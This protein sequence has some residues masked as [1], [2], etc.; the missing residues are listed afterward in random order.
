M[1]AIAP[2]RVMPVTSCTPRSRAHGPLTV[3]AVG[4]RTLGRPGRI[5]ELGGV[6]IV[7][8]LPDP[9]P[10]DVGH[11]RVLRLEPRQIV[12][13]DEVLSGVQCRAGGEREID[14]LAKVSPCEGNWRGALV[15]Q[16]DP[17][18][19]DILR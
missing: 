11:A 17:F 12:S 7:A 1:V 14:P 15:V 2:L 3:G 5:V 19:A 8:E 16:L 4:D 18:I 10:D 13:N 6:A 9:P